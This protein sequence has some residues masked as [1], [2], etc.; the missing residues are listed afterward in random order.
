M[1][2]V[3]N[4]KCSKFNRLEKIGLKSLYRHLYRHCEDLDIKKEKSRSRSSK[5]WD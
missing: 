5:D 1:Q 2:G 4:K 3:K